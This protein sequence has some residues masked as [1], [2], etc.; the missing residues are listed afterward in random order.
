MDAEAIVR[1]MANALPAFTL[2]DL[3]SPGRCVYCGADDGNKRLGHP[4]LSDP[5]QHDGG[6]PW[7]LA[8]RW[9]AEHPDEAN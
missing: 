7:A 4:P 3:I 9:V 8:A 1:A 6:C 5:T 2:D